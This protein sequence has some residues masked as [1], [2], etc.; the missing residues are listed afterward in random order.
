MFCEFRTDTRA[1]NVS[2]MST[3]PQTS[4][5]PLWQQTVVVVGG[6]G[7]IG[8]AVAEAAQAAGASVFAIS[9]SGQAP[10]GIHGLRA[11]A[12]DE[13]QLAVVLGECGRIDHLV[14]TAASRVGA[15]PLAALDADALRQA[16]EQKLFAA[17]RCV[18]LALPQLAPQASVVL[19]SGQISRKY[20]SGTWLKGAINAAMDTAG[21]HLAKELAPRRVNVV[22]PGVTDTALWG[23]D[24]STARRAALD[25]AAQLPVRRAAAPAEVAQAYL[26]AM[27]CGF[28]TGA[29]L[30][31][32]GGGLL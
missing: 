20:G 12:S 10:N 30:D 24:G 1:A 32:D 13:R 21:R 23:N 27:S 6:S 2:V 5:A 7:G 15:T 19:T 25:R 22:S 16:F 29:V 26:L 8:R 31:V 4:S 11:D 14:H 28:M 17:L 18:R 9:R 3:L